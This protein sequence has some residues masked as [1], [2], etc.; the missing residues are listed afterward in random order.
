MPAPIQRAV[1]LMPAHRAEGQRFPVVVALHGHGEAI[2]GPE[3]GVMGWPRDYALIHAMERIA[4]PPLTADDFE[5]L[6]EEEHLAEQNRALGQQPFRPLIV[7]CPYSPDVNLLD[8]AEVT[9]YGRALVEDVVPRVAKE[10]PALPAPASTG[11]DGVSLGGALAL[12]IGLGSPNV[13]GVVGALQPA[14]YEWQAS[15]MTELARS[16]RQKNPALK[17]RL[18]TSERDGFRRAVTR[19]SEAWTAAGITHDFA[20]RPGPHDYIFNRGPGAME[21]LF[22]HDRNLAH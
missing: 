13:F 9:R 16:A 22:W 15:E 3:A 14:L 18:T 21:L 10:L 6:V 1:V 20:I 4:A 2:K 7:V 8:P 11:I 5:G 17:L 12:R 19:T